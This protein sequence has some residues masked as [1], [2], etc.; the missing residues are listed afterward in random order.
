MGTSS[1]D[2]AEV[3][4][5]G[6]TAGCIVDAAREEE[7]LQCHNDTCALESTDGDTDNVVQAEW[8]EALHKDAL[9]RSR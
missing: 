4:D 9:D 7:C 6:F 3:G 2:G 1:P 8:Q 5:T